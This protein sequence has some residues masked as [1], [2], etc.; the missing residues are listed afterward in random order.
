MEKLLSKAW[1]VDA[2]NRAMHTFFQV[3]LSMITVGA[4]ITDIDWVGILS[5]AATATLI[6]ICKSILLIPLPEEDVDE[7]DEEGYFEID[8]FEEEE[9]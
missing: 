9:Q 2:G 7:D 3:L 5:V 6:S 8:S 1:W 4:A